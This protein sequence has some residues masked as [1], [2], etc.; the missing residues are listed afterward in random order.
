MDEVWPVGKGHLLF[1]WIYLLLAWAC[2]LYSIY[3]ERIGHDRRRTTRFARRLMIAGA[4]ILA[5]NAAWRMWTLGDIP[6][7]VPSLAGQTMLFLAIVL[8]ARSTLG[9][10]GMRFFRGPPPQEPTA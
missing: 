10:G 9:I 4:G 6:T 8:F 5:I 7:S 2:T 1:D 3:L